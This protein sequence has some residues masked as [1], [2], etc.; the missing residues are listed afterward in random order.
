MIVMHRRI[1]GQSFSDNVDIKSI[2]LH[3]NYFGNQAAY[4]H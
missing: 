3:V 1:R 2:N 4:I